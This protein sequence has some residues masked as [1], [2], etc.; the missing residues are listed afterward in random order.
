[1]AKKILIVDDSA[2]IRITLRDI[3]TTNG[4]EVVG[5]ADS[6]DDAIIKFK[7]LSPDLVTLDVVMPGVSGLE[8][9]QAII[10]LDRNAKVL[11]LTAVDKQSLIVE[12]IQAGAKGFL[13][14]PFSADGVLSEIKRILED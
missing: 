6:C 12:A 9:L 7:E 11:M 2:F 13:I 14:K 10:I 1:M 5:E 8:T 3:L 4:Y